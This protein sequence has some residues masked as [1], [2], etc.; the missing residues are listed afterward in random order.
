MKTRCSPLHNS[1]PQDGADPWAAPA[2]LAHLQGD[3]SS[4]PPDPAAPHHPA[5]AV[6]TPHNPRTATAVAA[7]D[8]SALQQRPR[9]T[10]STRESTHPSTSRPKQCDASSR[11]AR[12]LHLLAA[13]TA[14]ESVAPP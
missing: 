11:T 4:R 1:A 10:R 7:A 12:A 9:T 2:T 6:A 3:P 14:H 13:A 8:H 5:N